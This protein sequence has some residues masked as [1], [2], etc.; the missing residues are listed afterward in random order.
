MNKFASLVYFQVLLSELGSEDELNKALHS[1]LPSDWEGRALQI[2]NLK[3][4]LENLKTASESS[5]SSSPKLNPVRGTG[6]G[7]SRNGSLTPAGTMMK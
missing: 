1:E 2:K 4:Q 5:R 6:D 3:I 7:S